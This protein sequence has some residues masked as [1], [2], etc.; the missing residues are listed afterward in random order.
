M[1]PICYIIGVAPGTIIF[2]QLP[3]NDSWCRDCGA[4]FLASSDQEHPL[5]SLNFQYNAWGGKYPPYNLDQGVAE[6][7][8]KNPFGT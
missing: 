4:I 5:L 7:Y 8:G 3:T 6:F 1:F 2:H